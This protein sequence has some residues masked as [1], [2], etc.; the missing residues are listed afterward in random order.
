[1]TTVKEPPVNFQLPLHNEAALEWLRKMK[2]YQSTVAMA[3]GSAALLTGGWIHPFGWAAFVLAYKPLVITQK[4]ARL[5]KLT[6]MLWEEFKSEGIQVFPFPGSEDNHIDLFVRFPRT[7]HLFISIRSLGDR[8]V[9]YNE[10]KEVLQVRK[11][12][13][14]GLTTWKPCP[15]LELAAYEKWLNKNRDQ[16]FMTSREATKTPT[17]KVLVLWNPTK[18]ASNLNEHLYS[19]VG[20][21]RILALRRKGTMFVISQEEVIEF[22]RA[23]LA[24]YK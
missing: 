14:C 2:D 22:V 21:M 4:L 15:L 5:E 12:N 23:W 7:T 24:Q 3:A 18:P 8:E 9:V 11:K 19:S 10:A 20:N 6:T 1:M 16:F 17:A 13:K